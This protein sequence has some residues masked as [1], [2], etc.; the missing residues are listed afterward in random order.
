MTSVPR[1][2]AGVAYL[3]FETAKFLKQVANDDALAGSSVQ[4]LNEIGQY[5]YS[6]F[7]S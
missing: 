3:H 7:A 6:A 2:D 4:L 5:T 1:A